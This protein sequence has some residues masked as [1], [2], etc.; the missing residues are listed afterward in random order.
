[1]TESTNSPKAFVFVLPPPEDHL[2][3]EWVHAR[4]KV[5]AVRIEKELSMLLPEIHNPGRYVQVFTR[6]ITAVACGRS[7]EQA[8]AGHFGSKNSFLE[9]G[10]LGEEETSTDRLISITEGREEIPIFITQYSCSFATHT[11]KAITGQVICAGLIE[12]MTGLAKALIVIPSL[13]G[14]VLISAL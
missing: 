13:R 14:C 10:C 3:L 1:M 12:G 6:P 4:Y 7:I 2:T 11:L 9:T 5:L 8:I